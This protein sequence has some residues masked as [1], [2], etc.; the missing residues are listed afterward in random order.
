MSTDELRRDGEK[1]APWADQE[2]AF[3]SQEHDR[4]E[5]PF[6]WNDEEVYNLAKQA[7]EKHQQAV[8]MFAQVQASI[9]Q[10]R[11]EIAS[12]IKEAKDMR[13]QKSGYSLN[14]LAWGAMG[15]DAKMVNAHTK[16]REV[17]RFM[18]TYNLLLVEASTTM[19]TSY[20]Q[21]HKLVHG[22]ASQDETYMGLMA[23]S[24]GE[25]AEMSRAFA[26]AYDLQRQ[27]DEKSIQAYNPDNTDYR[28]AFLNEAAALRRQAQQILGNEVD[29]W[30]YS[31]YALAKE[32]QQYL[33]DDSGIH[34]T[35]SWETGPDPSS[36]KRR[37]RP[38]RS[39]QDNNC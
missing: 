34:D 15:A 12:Q 5:L 1:V 21:A 39:E 11:K 36:L 26:T 29:G 18:C 7:H 35:G 37:K 23:Q 32:A 22:D 10:D 20:A 4:S 13:N 38:R 6:P 24:L 14:P 31:S 16:Q 33:E 25:L 30:Q 9:K 19:S 2:Q 3:W 28:R 17:N 8:Q 27:T